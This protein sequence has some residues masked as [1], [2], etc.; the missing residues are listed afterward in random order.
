MASLSK[1]S[2]SFRYII[3]L[4]KY[5]S[6]IS[7]FQDVVIF[8]LHPCT[9]WIFFNYFF[10]HLYFFPFLTFFWHRMFHHFFVIFRLFKNS[11]RTLFIKFMPV[12]KFRLFTL[13]IIFYQSKI[14]LVLFNSQNFCFFR[15]NIPAL[16]TNNRIICWHHFFCLHV[17]ISRILTGVTIKLFLWEFLLKSKETIP[18]TLKIWNNFP[19]KNTVIVENPARRICLTCY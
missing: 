7:N 5:L 19:F 8:F 10:L 2:I 3:R 9:H 16:I 13:F 12:N 14:S 6:S 15:S 1:S 17:Q 18:P 4:P 11:H